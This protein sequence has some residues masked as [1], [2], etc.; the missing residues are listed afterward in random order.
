MSRDKGSE[1]SRKKACSLAL[2]AKEGIGG[3]S[4]EIRDS[5][6]SPLTDPRGAPKTQVSTA[7]APTARKQGR[8]FS[9]LDPLVLVGP[10]ATTLLLH[11]Q[12]QGPGTKV[13]R[14]SPY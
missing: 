6:C 4:G 10:P 9:H 7:P 8:R 13:M 3:V 5:R 11:S 1:S 2:P 12:Y 14:Q